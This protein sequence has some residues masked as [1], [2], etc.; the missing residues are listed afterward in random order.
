VAVSHDDA[1]HYRAKIKHH[2][3]GRNSRITMVAVPPGY[4]TISDRRTQSSWSVGVK[5]YLLGACPI[6]QATYFQVARSRPRSAQADQMPAETVSW[7]NA[8]QF[9][10]A[11]SEREGGHAGV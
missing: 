11:L 4:V 9:C 6:T 1:T 2:V 7:F 8:I 3:Y 10:N 5:A